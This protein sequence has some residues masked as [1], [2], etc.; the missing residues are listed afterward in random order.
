MNYEQLFFLL[1]DCLIIGA[2]V[3]R[4]CSIIY[5]KVKEILIEFHDCKKNKIREYSASLW[6]LKENEV[7]EIFRKDK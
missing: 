6:S 5:E 4:V 7:N 3:G 2:I 1:I